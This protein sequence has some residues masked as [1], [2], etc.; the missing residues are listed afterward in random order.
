MAGST[1]AL[2]HA[3]PFQRGWR[4]GS[5]EHARYAVIPNVQAYRLRRACAARPYDGRCR[6]HYE[7]MSA[8]LRHASD[9]CRA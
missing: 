2:S 5:V 1:P 6:L 8:A 7:E 9:G 4:T 3:P